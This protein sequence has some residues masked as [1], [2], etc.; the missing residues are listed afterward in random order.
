VTKKSPHWL[1][2]RGLKSK[3]IWEARASGAKADP[4]L[5]ISHPSQDRYDFDDYAEVL[6][7]CILNA[8]DDEPLTIGIEGGW[9]SGKTSLVY[10]LEYKFRRTYRGLGQ[11]VLLFDAWTKDQDENGA[12]ELYRWLL[13]AT[14]RERAPLESLADPAPDNL[15]SA[16]ERR[17]RGRRRSI[18]MVAVLLGA[19]AWFNSDGEFSIYD[20]L[21]LLC[22]LTATFGFTPAVFWELLRSLWRLLG[23]EGLHGLG[24]G[25]SPDEFVSRQRLA[26]LT[27]TEMDRI[28]RGQS[29]RFVVV[30]D[31][32]DRCRPRTAVEILEAIDQLVQ[33]IPLLVVIP[34][35]FEILATQLEDEY[36]RRDGTTMV[37]SGFGKMFL[38]RLVTMPF[39]MP[40]RPL[41]DPFVR[42]NLVPDD[43]EDDPA[44]PIL[45]LQG[46]VSLDFRALLSSRP[47]IFPTRYGEILPTSDEKWP[48]VRRPPGLGRG[49]R[50]LLASSLALMLG[51][52]AW[53]FSKI[54][55]QGY[56]L[57][58]RPE[59]IAEL[60]LPKRMRVLHA[61]ACLPLAA[62][63]VLLGLAVI[64]LLL[65]IA[66]MVATLVL[67]LIPHA[68]HWSNNALAGFE[69]LS[70]TVFALAPYGYGFTVAG[71]FVTLVVSSTWGSEIRSEDEKVVSDAVDGGEDWVPDE[72]NPRI[73]PARQAA[74]HM[75]FRE[76]RADPELGAARGMP[77]VVLLKTERG[78]KRMANRARIL[79]KLSQ[80]RPALGS[81]QPQEIVAWSIAQEVGA[82]SPNQVAP[83]TGPEAA[84]SPNSTWNAIVAATPSIET[85][86][87]LLRTL[88]L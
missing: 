53:L 34:A 46:N 52:P 21:W 5:P 76:V 66:T 82:R 48:T 35:D 2:P 69:A 57:A 12:D 42:P 22:L 4:S 25:N 80:R 50:A 27:V 37:Q 40:E 23:L 73:S 30:V 17:H 32:L 78:R 45:E 26:E 54:A 84:D 60:P 63:F 6:A 7:G 86:E 33:E 41:S 87:P 13:Q 55:R 67:A 36:K 49:L 29:S 70:A 3:S 38:E 81:L 24:K 18:A 75:L 44:A 11:K 51:T 28:L 9:G 71:F 8:P 64:A 68:S 61:L 65:S 62:G 88:G 56:P 10:L 59:W 19:L 72:G 20:P 43:S 1:N 74:L 39:R 58:R 77:S 14:Y 16:D 31:N 79:R 47:S 15:V 83:Q 85:R